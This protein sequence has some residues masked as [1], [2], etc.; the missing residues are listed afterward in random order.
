MA[1]AIDQDPFHCFRFAPR[2]GFDGKPMGVAEIDVKPGIPW[3]GPGFV[4]IEAML[5]PEI[6][7]F[8]KLSGPF[9]LVVGVYHITDDFGVDGDP[10]ASIILSNVDPSSGSM[11]LSTLDAMSSDVLRIRLRMSYDRLTF[12]F[13]RSSELNILD[14]I[15]AV[16]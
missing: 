12:V 4:E 6:I 7:E 10:S 3:H 11:D 15:A 13:G 5:K 1:R 9:P 14:K 8:A 2:V 16:V